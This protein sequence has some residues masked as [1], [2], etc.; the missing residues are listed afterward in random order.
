MAGGINL[1]AYVGNNPISYTDPFGTDKGDGGMALLGASAQL[2]A[3]YGDAMSGSL[4]LGVITGEG[5]L[6]GW[7]RS[8][9]PGAGAV[10]S[11]SWWYWGGAA[12]AMATMGGFGAAADAGSAG[13]GA[14]R[15]VFSGHGG[16]EV[17]GEG[18]KHEMGSGLTTIPEG[19]SLTVYSRLG[20]TISDSLGNAIETG[21]GLSGVYSKTFGP[22]MQ[23][24]N[25]TLFPAKGLNIMGNPVTVANP[26]RLSDL[27]VSGM[28]SCHWAA[29]T[30]ILY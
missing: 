13:A 15:T 9:T 4:L 29:C 1:Y 25:Y 7:I 27:L 5:S 28:G 24:P 20:G 6:S 14:T 22:G 3:G 8:K 21:Q 11:N 26:T 23:A 10:D 18:L 12:G 30:S 2:A 17:I 16:Y 19:T